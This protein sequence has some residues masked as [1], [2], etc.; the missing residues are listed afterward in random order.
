MLPILQMT[1]QIKDEKRW[2]PELE[3]GGQRDAR[4]DSHRITLGASG[5]SLEVQ[6]V[7]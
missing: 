2:R 4:L 5:H 6:L 7:R 1:H 3:R